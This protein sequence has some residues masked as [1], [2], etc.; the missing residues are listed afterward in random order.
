VTVAA[1]VLHL[2]R[3]RRALVIGG[4]GA[5]E[6]HRK[7]IEGALELAAL[8][9]PAT[10]RGKAAAYSR[11][12]PSIAA[13]RYG[14]VIYLVNYTGHQADDAVR[15]AKKAGAVVIYLTGGYSIARIVHAL[16]TQALQ[17]RSHD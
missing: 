3:G 1:A 6:D 8:D 5:R 2:T 16:E 17:R 11:M 4:Q 9:W 13:G 14:L 10:E 15:A 7:A 12:I